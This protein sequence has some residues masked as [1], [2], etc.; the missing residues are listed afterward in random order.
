MPD[1]RV[2]DFPAL[3]GAN[4]ATG[5]FIRMVDVSDTTDNAAGSDV[6]VTANELGVWM[7]R[8]GMPLVKSLASDATANSTTTA[9]KITSLDLAVPAAGTFVFQY[10]VRY[11]TSIIT[12]GVKFSVNHTG[13][14]TAF[15]T[16]MSYVDVSATASTGAPTQAQNAT[17]AGVM[18]A[19]SAR[20]KSQ[21]AG[22]GPT[23]SADATTDMLILIEG[24]LI[25]T[26]TGNMELWHASETAASTTV[27]AGTSLILT[28]TA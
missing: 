27:K 13:T 17:T 19:Y 3:T 12:T 24:L 2:T 20:A 5:D 14:L 16:N 9:A 11:V 1:E 18:G 22:M 15:M 8:L 23:L 25:A 10:W 28:R 26:T 7:Q 6:K 21:A 4:I